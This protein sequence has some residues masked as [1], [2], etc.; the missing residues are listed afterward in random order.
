MG[1]WKKEW[2]WILAQQSA[3]P[4]ASASIPRYR[5]GGLTERRAG[6]Q[7][8]QSKDE[9]GLRLTIGPIC[10]PDLA[11]SLGLHAMQPIVAKGGRGPGIPAQLLEPGG[12]RRGPVFEDCDSQLEYLTRGHYRSILAFC[13]PPTMT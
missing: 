2:P 10:S 5:P 12:G 6:S 11:Q 7:A 13:V 1:R 8:S 4:P 9:V 3:S